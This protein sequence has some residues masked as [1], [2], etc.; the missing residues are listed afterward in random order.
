[1]LC[2]INPSRWLLKRFL[3]S[4]YEAISTRLLHKINIIKL[5]RFQTSKHKFEI[6]SIM[7][8]SFLTLYNVYQL[9]CEQAKCL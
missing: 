6:G 8:F 5:E 3:K 1:M 7:E 4:V 2:G 9:K